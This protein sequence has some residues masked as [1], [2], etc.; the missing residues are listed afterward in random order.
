MFEPSVGGK[1]QEYIP[2]TCIWQNAPAC[3]TVEA[4]SA[5]DI[6]THDLAGYFCIEKYGQ[7]PFFYIIGGKMCFSFMDA[8]M[9]PLLASVSWMVDVFGI[10]V[11]GPHATCSHFCTDNFRYVCVEFLKPH[12]YPLYFKL[13]QI[14]V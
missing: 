1:H 6:D 7:L 11:E 9:D 2:N 10:Y 5:I 14:L 13:Q 8:K 3:N 12:P 4:Y